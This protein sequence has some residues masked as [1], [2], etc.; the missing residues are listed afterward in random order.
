MTSWRPANGCRRKRQRLPFGKE[1]PICIALRHAPGPLSVRKGLF[2]FRW[3]ILPRHPPRTSTR[4][5]R[6]K[7]LRT[8]T[9]ILAVALTLCSAAAA[10]ERLRMSTTTSTENSGL[11]K[12][13]LPPFEA[14]NS[15]KVDV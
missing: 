12:V 7:M 6:M 3:D 14:Q 8:L 1:I 11:L 2:S 4:E 13:L 9:A 15:C 10:E 5:E